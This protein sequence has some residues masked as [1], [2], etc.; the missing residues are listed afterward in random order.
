MRTDLTQRDAAPML[1]MSQRQ[2]WWGATFILRTDGDPARYGNLVRSELEAVDPALPM[3]QP[4]TLAAV[5]SDDLAARRLP[6]LLMLTF[7]ALALLLACIGIYALFANMAAAREREF[8]VRMALGSSRAAVAQLMLRQGALWMALGLAGGALGV[9]AV[10]RALR[11]L[12]YGIAP[13][14]HVSIAA[15]V[16]ALVIAAGVALAVPVV[17]ATRSDPVSVMR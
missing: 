8:G 5:L 13:L 3:T 14:H 7:S 6:M 4:Q 9:Y 17:R 12:V 2:G 16:G 1:Y 10:S 11:I 15:A